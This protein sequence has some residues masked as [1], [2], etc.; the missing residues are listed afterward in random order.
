M[1]LRGAAMP[2]LLTGRANWR[3]RR[4]RVRFSLAWR[5]TQRRASVADSA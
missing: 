1:S 5:K 4:P 2:C 3:E